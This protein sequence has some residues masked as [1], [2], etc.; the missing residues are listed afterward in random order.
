MIYTVL[1]CTQG[2]CAAPNNCE[3]PCKYLNSLTTGALFSIAQT[4][5]KDNKIYVFLLARVELEENL[6]KFK[7]QMQDFGAIAMSSLP[8]KQFKTLSN[9]SLQS[10]SIIA[11]E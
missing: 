2:A 1:V 11:A 9:K 8:E 3:V 7:E 4:L 5:H 6:E 10:T